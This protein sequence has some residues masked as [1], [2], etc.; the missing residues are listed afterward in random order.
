VFTQRSYGITVSGPGGCGKSTL[1]GYFTQ[2]INSGKIFAED[3]C[4]L[5]KDE[6]KIVT[7]FIDAPK[8]EMTTLKYFWTSIIDSLAEESMEFLDKFATNLFRKCLH[9]L[10]IN[11]FKRDQLKEALTNIIPTF[12]ESVKH[13]KIVDLLEIDKFYNH[14]IINE[15]SLIRIKDLIMSGWRVLQSHKIQFGITGKIGDFEQHRTLKVNKQSFDLLFDILS[16]DYKKSITAQ[17][18]FKG[19]KGNLIQSDSDVINLFNWLTNTWEWIEEEP[20]SL[21][22]GVDNIG[23]LT[24]NVED[25]EAAYIPFVQTILQIR[26]SLKNFLFILIGTNEDWRL[27]NEYISKYQDFRTQLRGF[28]VNKIDLTRLTLSE[29]IESLSLVVSRFWIQAGLMHES[30]PLY[31]FSK[32]LFTYLYEYHAHEY[33]NILINLQKIWNYY[34]SSTRV[35]ELVDPFLIIKFIR[36]SMLKITSNFDSKGSSF[37][38]LFY[39]NLIEWEKKA[40]KKHFENIPS[41]HIGSSQ[42]ELVETKLAESLRVLQEKEIPKQID[43]AEKTPKIS[44]ETEKGKKTRYPD[45]YVK[46][47]RQKISESRRTFEI[48]IKMYD[49]NKYVKL[50]DIESSIEL[51]ERAYTDALLFVMTGAGLEEKAINEINNKDLGERVLYFRSLNDEQQTALAFLLYYEK[52]T[53]EKP[54]VSIIKEILEI[55]F[56]ESWDRLIELIRNIGSYRAERIKEKVNLKQRSTLTGYIR[57]IDQEVDIPKETIFTEE[58]ESE[59]DIDHTQKQE[60]QNIPNEPYD[61]I[62]PQNEKLEKVIGKLSLIPQKDLLNKLYLRY[63]S[64]INELKFIIE[65]IHKRK[66][67]YSKQA[68][69]D[70]LKKRVPAHL[71]DEN[72]SELFLRLKNEDIKNEV[73]DDEKLFEYKGTSIHVREITNIFYQVIKAIHN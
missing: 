29:A 17:E 52:I 44:I 34:K 72:I 70:Y 42:S 23:Y 50:K 39:S 65:C 24:F 10:W 47:T 49:K 73:P 43:W 14:L 40:I 5:K 13:H 26:N 18:I 58:L 6:C 19:V 61:S 30:N 69:K 71:S 64:N 33:R 31:P 27:F 55:I 51:L 32:Q 38:E 67:R 66:G 8:G 37:T 48:Q 16:S 22:V 45:V 59:I 36:I 2:L 41:R 54:T 12:E 53:G 20:I 4:Q 1:F 11:N 35:I 57:D 63:F 56:E 21:L 28:L 15:N 7:C 9:V 68:T 46:L 60:P 25:E 62:Q 3:Y